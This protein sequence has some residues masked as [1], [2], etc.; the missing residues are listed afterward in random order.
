MHKIIEDAKQVGKSI[1]KKLIF[2]YHPKD[3]I[4]EN[5]VLALKIDLGPYI[6]DLSTAF[7]YLDLLAGK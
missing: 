5:C 4:G 7:H 6:Q 3:R 2:I 1:R